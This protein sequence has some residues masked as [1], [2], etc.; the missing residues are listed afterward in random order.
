MDDLTIT[1]PEPLRQHVERRAAA[2][3]LESPADFIR[4]LVERDRSSSERL[5]AL[6]LE[7]LDSEGESIEIDD[8]F[9]AERHAELDRRLA[10][11]DES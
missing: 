10:E 7:S 1:L 5:E 3:G 2:A 4:E 6:L 8:A 9:W 11:R